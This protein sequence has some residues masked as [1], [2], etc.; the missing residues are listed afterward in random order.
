[1]SRIDPELARL[2][3]RAVELDRGGREDEARE[4]YQAYLDR[5]P[6]DAAAWSNLGGLLSVAGR[7]DEAERACRCALELAPDCAAAKVNLAH[8]LLRMDRVDE[9]E[10]WCR[11]VLIRDAGHEEALVALADVHMARRDLGRTRATLDRLAALNPTREE[12]R[13]RR[14]NL[15]IHL[16]DWPA[17]RQ[18]AEEG[19]AE[20]PEEEAA[21]Q[22]SH[23]QLMF[24]EFH[25]GWRGYEAR[26]RI[27]GRIVRGVNLGGPAWEG[28]SFQGK[29]LLVHWEQGHGDTLMLLRYLPMVKARGGT[30]LLVVQPA[31][32]EVA[33]TCPGVDVLCPFGGPRPPH[34][35]HVFLM[36]LPRIFHTEEARI[37]APV[38]YLEVP[39]AP[40][41]KALSEVLAASGDRIR[42]GLTWAGNP[43]HARDAE[44]SIACA[45]W[46]PLGALADV[47]WFGLQVG[48]DE[49]PALPGFT[50]LA[51][52]LETFSDT[53]FALAGLD[54]LITVDT[55]VAHLAGA[56]GIPTF[57]LLTFQ[58][59]WR[60]MLGREDSP[61]YPT[62]RLYRQPLP[63]DWASVIQRVAA[64]LQEGL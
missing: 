64:D 40:H 37:P 15:A 29:T 41:G 10:T 7:L 63:G 39:R 23:W 47:A 28:E 59:D 6:A 24:G 56:L 17:L 19:W 2:L 14:H 45:A 62:F 16:Q 11:S 57:L 43:E 26:L 22:R 54:L 8:T 21:Y 49:T 52:L 51:P 36:S 25:E 58:P 60:W 33:A 30:V 12:L 18:R 9:A 42:I 38:P 1:M 5:N 50:S 55:A 35:L 13:D 4:A 31:L 27:P 53:A 3:D 44:R 46:S 32:M 20:L 48:R 34:D 61:W